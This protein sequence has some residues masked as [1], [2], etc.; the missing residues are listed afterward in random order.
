M[1]WGILD[2]L[3]YV[4]VDTVNDHDRERVSDGSHGQSQVVRTIE[5]E[6][7]DVASIPILPHYTRTCPPVDLWSRLERIAQFVW[8][9]S[10]M[11]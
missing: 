6:R 10:S 4:R 3:P 1:I 8:R 9:W 7:A 11:I 5:T 2:A